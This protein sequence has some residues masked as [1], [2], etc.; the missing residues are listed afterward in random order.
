VENID[1]LQEV[2]HFEFSSEISPR[3]NI[4]PGQQ[5]LTVVSEDGNRVGKTMKWGLV[6]SWSKEPKIGYKMI[7]ARA[8]GIESKPSFKN[9]FKRRRTLIPSSGFYEWQK[10]EDGK[11]PY[12]FVLK[13]KKPFAFAGLWESWNNGDSPLV[14]CT[15]ITTIPNEVTAPIHDRSP[16]ILHEDVYDKWLDPTLDDIEF[17]KSLLVP[18]PAEEMERYPV[19][20]IVNSVK[21]N[22]A[23]IITPLN[24]L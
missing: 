12:R 24:S 14:T 5:I 9:A 13:N 17:L 7:N 6:P 2:F 11:Q 1:Q 8:E 10:T 23:E 21:N 3:T 18:Y 16:V 20:T 4:A 19:S 22:H 15:I